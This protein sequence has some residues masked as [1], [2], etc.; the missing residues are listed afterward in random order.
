M[1]TYAILLLEIFVMEHLVLVLEKNK[2]QNCLL[3]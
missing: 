2:K 3:T 1:F